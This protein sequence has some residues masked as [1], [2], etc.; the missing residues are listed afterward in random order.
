ML[1][2]AGGILPDGEQTGLFQW[3]DYLKQ[4]SRSPAGKRKVVQILFGATNFS[5]KT[6]P[7][8][9]LEYDFDAF[10]MERTRQTIRDALD[11]KGS[12]PY[13]SKKFVTPLSGGNEMYSEGDMRAGSGRAP[14]E[15]KKGTVIFQADLNRSDGTFL[16]EGI[17]M[18]RRD[19]PAN[20]ACANC[21]TPHG[22]KACKQCGQRYYCGKECQRVR[23]QFRGIYAGVSMS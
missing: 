12:L 16:E 11:S 4:A 19:N 8:D 14:K 20:T 6:P 21:G 15:M 22:L 5:G 13:A 17:N 9:P 3:R 10:D 23:P 18:T 1:D 7:I 2:G